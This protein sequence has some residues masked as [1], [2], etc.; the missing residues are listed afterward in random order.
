MPATKH[1]GIVGVSY[2]GAALCYRIIRPFPSVIARR[3]LC[4]AFSGA[5]RLG[6][7]PVN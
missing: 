5:A 6:N 1:I 2:E 7:L 4:A 3:A